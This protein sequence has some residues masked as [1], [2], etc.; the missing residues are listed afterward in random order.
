MTEYVR[1]IMNRFRTMVLNSSGNSKTVYEYLEQGKVDKAIALMQNRDDE[2]DN[3]IKEYNTQTHDIMKRPNK[4]RKADVPYITEKLPR[5]RQK[6][7]NEVELFFLLGG[8]IKWIK[9]E[10]DDEGFKLFTSFL[11]DVHF[12]SRMRTAKRL[13]GAETESAKLYNIYKDDEGKV[14]VRCVILARSTGYTLRPMFDEYGGLI[15]FA[16]GYTQRVGKTNVQHWDFQTPT[17]LFYCTKKSTGYEVRA[18]NNPTGKINV[19]YYRQ[20][21][22]WDGV[23]ERIKREEY[24]D[25]KQ[26][27]TNNYFADPIAAATADVINSMLD[28]N[29]VGSFIQLNGP[30]S[31]FEYI[32]PPQ[33]SESAKDERQNLNSSILFDSF[34]PDLSFDNL[35]GM[36]TISGEAIKNSMVLGFM[37]S[38][39]NKEIYGELVGRER[40]LI[41][42]ILS[43]VY[44][45]EAKMKGLRV[46]FEFGEPFATDEWSRLLELYSK[47]LI[48]VGELSERLHVT[49]EERPTTPVGFN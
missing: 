42:S 46:G 2:V 11:E 21:K 37:K 4:I 36:G 5:A 40:N 19:I 45:E 7:I 28:T 30:G 20:P 39:K 13:A 38:S 16:Y 48:S 44:L 24:L 17:M 14:R 6:Y 32:N 33:S 22:A 25:S 41:I 18:E 47:G 12:N 27:D 9:K 35:K 26:A 10:G 1:E 31:Q 8:G 15:A 34:T 29:T 49:L 3:A 23:E 43:Y